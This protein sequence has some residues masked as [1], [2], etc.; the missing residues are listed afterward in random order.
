[1]DV[2]AATLRTHPEIAVFLA[3]G[4]GYWI[5]RF[6]VRGVGFGPV[7][8][9]LIAGLLVGYAVEVPVADT[10]KQLLFLLFMFGIG[11]S[12]GPG[13]VRG[14]RDAGWRWAVLGSVIPLAGLLTAW[15]MAKLLDLELGYAVGMMSGGLTESPVIGTASEAIRALPISAEEKSRLIAQIPV[16][17]ALTYLFG[18]IGVIVFCGYVGPWLLRV[19][20]RADARRLEAA[21]G[22]SREADGVDSGWRMFAMRAYRLE[23]RH[24]VVGLPVAEAERSAAPAR[25]F[26]ERIRRDGEVIDAQ[27]E[28]VLRAGDVVAV[29]AARETMVRLLAGVA[30]EVHDR[31][32]L[33][34]PVATRDVVLSHASVV[35]RSVAELRAE[36]TAFR[37]VFLQAIRRAGRSLPVAPQTRLEQ[38]DVITLHGLAPAVDRIA[39]LAGEPARSPRGADFVALGLA[40]GAGALAGVLLSLPVA[41]LHIALGSSVAVLLVGLALG[42]RNAQ[43]PGF[44]HIPAAAIEFMKSLGLSAFVAMIGLKAGPVFVDAIREIGLS[45]FLGG[46]VVTLVPQFVGLLVGRYLLRIEPLLLLGALAGAQTMTAALAAVQDRSDSPVAVIGYSSTVAFGH[47]LISIGGTV[48]VWMLHAG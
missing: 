7:T 46:I 35:G 20:L 16:A 34:V 26:I 3:I 17:D 22:L 6:S 24:R 5:G 18:T 31:R 2:L 13:F 45:V 39:S 48:L 38:G 47:I 11:Y 25:L 15:A 12:A 42:W 1:M 14:L 36:T 23:P 28:T 44:A 29:I 10:A 32:L 21:M 9:S 30:E 40:I 8:G 4:L 27:P 43:H 33:D 41:G 37:G 19:D